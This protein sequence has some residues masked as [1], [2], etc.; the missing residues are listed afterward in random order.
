MNKKKK[1]PMFSSIEP[2]NDFLNYHI[3]AVLKLKELQTRFNGQEI[4]D[5][6]KLILSRFTEINSK[7]QNWFDYSITSFC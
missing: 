4:V 2:D 3:H 5:E 6:V 1:L 7:D